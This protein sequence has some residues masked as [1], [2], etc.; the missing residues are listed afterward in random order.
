[1]KYRLYDDQFKVEAVGLAL[2]PDVQ[3]QAFAVKPGSHPLMLSRWK[4]E[5]RKGRF[6]APKFIR[7]PPIFG[8]ERRSDVGRSVS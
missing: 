7:L 5:Y 8:D 4:K 1:M 6:M 2:Q 3:I